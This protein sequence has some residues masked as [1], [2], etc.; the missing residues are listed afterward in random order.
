[1]VTCDDSS[2]GAE[3]LRRVG[4]NLADSGGARGFGF[5]NGQIQ[6]GVGA[7]MTSGTT[8][9]EHPTLTSH[10]DAQ[11][12]EFAHPLG[13]FR[14]E[15]QSL[16][17]PPSRRDLERL[18]DFARNLQLEDDSL[19]EEASEI[20]ASLEA[21]DLADQMARGALPVVDSLDPRTEDGRCHFVTPVRFGRRRSDQ[22]GHLELTTSWLKFRG[23]LDV[24][25]VWTEIVM[26]ERMGR[27]IIVRLA[28]SSRVLR[29]CCHAP[30]EAAR[31]SV[32]AAYLSA[33]ARRR[34]AVASV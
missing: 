9:A 1:M 10:D 27:E 17:N 32:I 4:S 25:I 30:I 13:D 3:G 12:T 6:Y 24:S 18:L 33:A 21:L 2:G 34:Q 31:G 23:A 14:R 7:A 29:F 20:R 26:A 28:D 16:P 19:G 11:V 15:L 5:V 8:G 22:F